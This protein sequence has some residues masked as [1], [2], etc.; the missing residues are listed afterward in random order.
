MIRVVRSNYLLR[1]GLI[2]VRYFLSW[3]AIRSMR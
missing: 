3:M 2:R 1:F